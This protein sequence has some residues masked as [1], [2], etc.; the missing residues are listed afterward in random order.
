MFR[1]CW[2]LGGSVSMVCLVAC[3]SS[4]SPASHEGSDAGRD[5]G[6]AQEAGVRKDA[7]SGT[8]DAGPAGPD[9]AP[10][11]D[12]ARD[13]GASSRDAAT[14]PSHVLVTYSGTS[15]AKKPSALVA[16]NLTTH[17]VD[18]ILRTTDS[19]AVTDTSNAS[20]P[21]LLNQSHDVVDEVDPKTWTVAG[22]WSVAIPGDAGGDYS[23]P[24][25][26]S[27]AT[28]SEV[29][30][31]RYN[32]NVIDVLD[33]TTPADGG[34]PAHSVDL[35]PLAQAKGDGV[36]HAVAG[37]YVPESKLLYVVLE[38]LNLDTEL[39]YKGTYYTLCSGTTSSVIAIDTVHDKVKSLG[40]SAPGGGIALK[41]F[42]PTAVVYDAVGERLLL[43]N[44]GCHPAP[45]TMGGAPG[46]Q[47]QAGIEEVPLG[48]GATTVLLDTSAQ[49]GFPGSFVYVGP[50]EA[51]V[52]FQYPTATYRWDPTKSELGA[53]LPNAP[54]VFDYDGAGNLVG[55]S[56]SY[57][58]GGT[59]TTD[60]VSMSLA[61]GDATTLQS[62]VLPLGD[63]YI[64][65]VGVWPRP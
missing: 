22:S 8:R 30:V 38:N 37:V 13:S 24:Y 43:L 15:S 12:A 10:G 62:N 26:V 17:A 21:F 7:S 61:T 35:T 20:A 5:A 58:D 44:A 51:V 49:T 1:Q 31:L 46:A 40:G 50:T 3:S 65:S 41:E 45:A 39:D 28:E 47:Q 56:V 59:A 52:A 29:Y 57:G 4:S 19:Q 18:G 2:V 42:D 55:A 16:V 54:D 48:G 25:A 60:I 27:V 14:T 53:A 32:V 63:G 9:A 36:V 6:H 11:G 33:I 64:S 34:K 23:D